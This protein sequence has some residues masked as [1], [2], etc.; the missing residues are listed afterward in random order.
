[1]AP[2]CYF[3]F[4]FSLLALLERKNSIKLHEYWKFETSFGRCKVHLDWPWTEFFD[5]LLRV[6]PRLF[7]DKNISRIE[8]E[9]ILKRLP[10]KA[11][12]TFAAKKVSLAI[13]LALWW[14]VI[15][16]CLVF[17][18]VFPTYLL[19]ERDLRCFILHKQIVERWRSL[20][21]DV[22]GLIGLRA[23]W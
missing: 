2:T 15:T 11:V 10:T 6:S 22:D 8:L 3:S 5:H 1:M 23:V 20:V 9:E 7:M 21:E 13:S 17:Q 16:I 4:R 18:F 19:I 12:E 14:V